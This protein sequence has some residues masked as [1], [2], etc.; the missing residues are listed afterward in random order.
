ML[1]RFVFTVIVALCFLFSG[2]AGLILEVVWTK[3]LNLIF[4][5]TT[6]S[7]STTVSAF[8]GGL[9]LGSYLADRFLKYLKNPILSYGIFEILI[10]AY[11][12]II[13]FILKWFTTIQP[14][15]NLFLSDNPFL[16]SIVRFIF[17]FLVL[18]I[19]TTAMGATLPIISTY[20]IR[21]IRE[22]GAKIGLLY[23]IN[24]AG[25]TIGTFIA[26]FYLLRTFGVQRTNN[27][28][29]LIDVFIGVSMVV[30]SLK[31]AS[32]VEDKEKVE[33]KSGYANKELRVEWILI[34]VSFISG[35]ISMLYQIMW[36]RSLSM[37]IGSSTYAFT[38]IL[39]TF[40]LGISLGSFLFSR[41][42]IKRDDPISDLILVFL[43]IGFSAL[44]TSVYIDRLPFLVQKI[45]LIDNFTPS[46]IFWGYFFV[47]SIVVVVPAM[48]MGMYIPMIVHIALRDINTV[49]KD[50]G[51]IYSA[52]TVGNIIGSFLGGF[53]IIPCI[54]LQ[55]GVRFS[56]LASVLL[57]LLLMF[58]FRRYHIVKDIRNIAFALVIIVFTSI[59]PK[60][61]IAKWSS[62]M[63]R[64]YLA[65]G[66][67]NKDEFVPPKIIFHKDG[68]VT[69]VTVEYREGG[70]YSLKVNGKVDASNG[71]DMSTQ[72]LSGLIPV[73]L[74]PEA[75]SVAVIGFGSGTTS[76]AVLRTPVGEVI[77]VELEEAVIEASRYFTSFNLEPLKSPKH[78]LRVDDGRNFILSTDRK[79]DI[80]ISEPSNPWMSGAS[81]LFTYDFWSSASKKLNQK[82]IFCQWLQMYELSLDNIKIL[83]NTFRKV[84]PHVLLFQ[85]YQNSNDTLL[86]GS[87]DPLKF[88]YKKVWELINSE[89]LKYELEKIN[90]TDPFDVFILIYYTQNEIEQFVDTDRINTDDNSLIEFLAPIDLLMYAIQKEDEPPPALLKEKV[91]DRIL[92]MMEDKEDYDRE[93]LMQ[94]LAEAALKRG[95]LKSARRSTSEIR[96][97]EKKRLFERVIEYMDGAEYTFPFKIVGQNVLK[98]KWGYFIQ[99]LKQENIGAAINLVNDKKQKPVERRVGSSL[100]EI[101]VPPTD[102]IEEELLIGYL[103]FYESSYYHAIYLW[104]KALASDAG[105]KYPWIYYYLGRAYYNLD[106]FAHSFTNFVKYI[107]WDRDNFLENEVGN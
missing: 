48:G 42:I 68:I 47:T 58:Y 24:T 10:G 72:I 54:G 77:S 38:I 106:E 45:M 92:E 87:F 83:I 18:I 105:K 51:R 60:W 39:T 11:A 12:L 30:F 64:A 6:L 95:K 29:A 79:F 17:C 5:S 21:N 52:N 50:V 85:S 3:Y 91:I 1:N 61:D 66:P 84:F 102:N 22:G 93:F 16:Y 13:P 7:I 65:R 25:A 70:L 31:A 44:F 80:I 103:Y 40:L 63:F 94:K 23:A 28:A 81:S 73:F 98:E 62:G 46:H 9:A 56:V 14:T 99:L 101:Y 34:V 19:P 104:E 55:L 32:V 97:Y 86:I 2:A 59:A 100:V 27:V 67:Y 69:T 43:V 53:V 107:E 71:S 20:Y 82:G 89:G 76:G 41:F 74:N 75:K 78:K 36:T 49:T 90:V 57:G 8:M 26:G 4:G 35:I 96:D 15:I 88:N 33:D 37:V